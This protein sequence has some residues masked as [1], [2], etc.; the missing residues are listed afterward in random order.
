MMAILAKNKANLEV[1]KAT[2]KNISLS[3]GY[4]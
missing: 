3:F 4:D 1:K 2:E